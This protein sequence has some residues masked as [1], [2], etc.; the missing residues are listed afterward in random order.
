MTRSVPWKEVF[1][2]F[3]YISLEKEAHHVMKGPRGSIRFGSGGRSEESVAQSLRRGLAGRSGEQ[4]RT[5][6]E[7][8]DWAD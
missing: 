3:N 6:E 7:T 5:T 2:F 1:L 4:H 8:Q